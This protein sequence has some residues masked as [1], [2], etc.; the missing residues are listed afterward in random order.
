MYNHDCN[1]IEANESGSEFEFALNVKK[2]GI[3]ARDYSYKF[4]NGHR[5]FSG[6]FPKLV[7]YLDGEECDAILFSLYSLNVEVNN[8]RCDF[9]MDALIKGKF[10]FLKAVFYEEFV[11]G[12]GDLKSKNNKRHS[13]KFV[14]VFR[15]GDA[16]YRRE[17]NQFFGSMKEVGLEK[18]DEYVN[19]ELPRRAVG[20][21][22]IVL[23]GESN[24]VRYR[25]YDKKIHDEHGM[26]RNIPDKCNLILNPLHDRMTRFEMKLKREFL[27]KAGRTV[28]SVWN[29]GRGRDGNKAPWTVYH[30][31]KFFDVAEHDMSQYI[32]EDASYI[33]LAVVDLE[34]FSSNRIQ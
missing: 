19:V 25:R 22:C 3:V 24:A 27:S 33:F 11:E 14:G 30:N 10:K 15:D 8:N 28:V 18:I 12:G 1:A 13:R 16:W 21:C 26:R 23:C 7:S 9:I 17:W 6:V 5:D 31:G 4:S 2:L 34:K 29:R 20:N 32:G